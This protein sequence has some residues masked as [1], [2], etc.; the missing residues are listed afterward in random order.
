MPVALP[1]ICLDFFIAVGISTVVVSLLLVQLRSTS[2]TVFS[3][4]SAY[5]GLVDLLVPFVCRLWPFD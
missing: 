4:A 3:V 2:F 5:A 1:V